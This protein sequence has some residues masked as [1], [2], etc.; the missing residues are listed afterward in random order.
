MSLIDVSAEL[1]NIQVPAKEKEVAKDSPGTHS[2]KRA[3]GPE[4]KVCI[5][6]KELK[7]EMRSR[8]DSKEGPW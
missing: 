5:S 6:K 7:K 1:D 2:K 8:I 3:K 4:V